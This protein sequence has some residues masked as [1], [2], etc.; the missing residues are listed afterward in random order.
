LSFFGG[1]GGASRNGV[2]VKGSNYLEALNNIRT[3]VFDKTGTL[4]RGTFNVT[5]VNAVGDINEKELLRIAAWAEVYSNHPIAVSII[6][7]YG[8]KINKDAVVNYNEISGLGIKAVIEDRRVVI[9]NVRL[10]EEEKVDVGD[11]LSRDTGTVICV[12]I[13]GKYAGNMI[14]TDELKKDAKDTIKNL[15]Q[16]GIDNIVMLTGDSNSV[17]QNVAKSLGIDKVYTELLPDQKVEKL[18]L[19]TAQKARSGRVVFVGDGI[20][21]APVLARADIGIAMGNLGSDAAIEAA[22]IVLMTDEPSKIV[23]AIKI[24]RRTNKIVW[25]NIVFALEVK[26]VVLILGTGGIATMWEA[27]FADVGVAL[28]AIFNAMRAM[29]FEK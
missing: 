23:S 11:N 1:I 14:I 3:I 26:I 24:A 10:M 22:D 20:N 9:G 19:I 6:K 4:T 21:D 17:G 5:K 28:I 12:A 7:A 29:K 27:V 16:I 18:E 25:Q 8:G 2:L 13:N 15:Q